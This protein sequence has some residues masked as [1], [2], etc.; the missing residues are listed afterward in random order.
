MHGPSSNKFQH[1]PQAVCSVEQ[2]RRS[3]NVA[4]ADPRS[5][6]SPDAFNAPTVESAEFGA[7]NLNEINGTKSANSEPRELQLPLDLV[8]GSA[9][10]IAGAQKA[11]RL[12]QAAFAI[13]A[14]VGTGDLVI[15]VDGM[16]S[17]RIPRRR[18]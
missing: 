10:R 14:E 9:H 4:D 12:R 5:P 16:R 3:Q 17:Y 7:G 8:G 2:Q 11:Q 15:S 13:D 6:Y 18:R 1:S